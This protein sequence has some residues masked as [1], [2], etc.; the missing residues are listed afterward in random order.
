MAGQKVKDWAKKA[1]ESLLRCMPKQTSVRRSRMLKAEALS[2]PHKLGA[3]LAVPNR[4]LPEKRR[5]G[6]SEPC[7]RS[8]GF[9][10]CLAAWIST[11]RWQGRMA[12]SCKKL[13][14]NVLRNTA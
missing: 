14:K 3:S 10:A 12:I 11:L 1:L 8:S 5:K 4:K 2:H 9:K 6:S 13:V 7:P